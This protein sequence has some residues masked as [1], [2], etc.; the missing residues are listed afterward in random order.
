MTSP[1]THLSASDTAFLGA[2]PANYERYLVPLIFEFYADDIAA[3]TAARRPARILETAAGTGVVTRRLV[4]ELPGTATITGT[5]LNQSMIDF[6]AKKIVAPNLNWRQADATA[7]PFADAAFDAVVCQF[8]VMFF[9]DRVK[10]YREAWRVLRPGGAFIFNVWDRIEAN[11]FARTV[12]DALAELFPQDPPKFMA[13]TPHGYFDLDRILADLRAAGFDDVSHETLANISR[14][15]DAHDVALG[16]C[17][18]SPL[19]AE[20]EARAPGEIARVTERVAKAVARRH[21]TG[22]IEG[23]IRA[24]RVIAER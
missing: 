15:A 10:G 21:G 1:S 2:V 24:H 23:A 20:I 17:Q 14:A 16:L 4:R 9:P 22:A 6:A 19:A 11:E 3:R 12:T 7:L 8:G 13:R 18:G 5:D